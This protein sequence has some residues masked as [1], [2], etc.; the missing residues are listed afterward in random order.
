ML[1]VARSTVE[2]WEAESGSNDTS[3]NASA[4]PA[5]VLPR[6]DA[7]KATQEAPAPPVRTSPDCRVKV[8]PEARAGGRPSSH[9]SPARRRT[10]GDAL[11][12][13]IDAGRGPTGGER[14]SE[15]L[16]ARRAGETAR[17]VAPG[18]DAGPAV[19]Q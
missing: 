1:G 5:P 13:G 7:A 9:T 14:R 19:G 12:G 2:S 17:H 16:T 4:P 15:A 10:A 18:R 11:R 8:A 3:V 6:T